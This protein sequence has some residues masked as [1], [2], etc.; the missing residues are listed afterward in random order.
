M[1]GKFRFRLE[2]V[3]G[4]RRRARDTSRRLLAGAISKVQQVSDRI[5]SLK[6]QLC[7]TVDRTRGARG[8][9][10]L[11]VAVLRE[12][13]L[14]RGELHRRISELT[15]E[16]ARAEADLEHKRHDLVEA[17][18]RLKVIEK[19]RERHWT[20]YVEE[21]GREEQ[22]AMDETATQA[23]LRDYRRTAAG[24]RRTPA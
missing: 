22:R 2:T 15:Q 21:R 12:Q 4:L 9:G 18:K 24:G 7:D 10:R 16:L 6:G 20:R 17:S 1:A 5:A 3:E 8:R 14:Y 23:Y 11:D 13:Q 19:L